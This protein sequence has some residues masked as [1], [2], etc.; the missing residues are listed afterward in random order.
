[1]IR[2]KLNARRGIFMRWNEI[3]LDNVNEEIK[4]FRN[5]IFGYNLYGLETDKIRN[6]VESISYVIVDEDVMI[7]SFGSQGAVTV[8][9][10][11]DDIS[12]RGNV[13]EPSVEFCKNLTKLLTYSSLKSIKFQ[14]TMA[15]LRCQRVAYI[16]S[17]QFPKLCMRL[18]M[19]L[20]INSFLLLY[21]MKM[22]VRISMMT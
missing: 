18:K 8:N 4:K 7:F 1:M 15:A 2:Y 5:H 21:L 11:D 13:P 12:V 3:I 14:V 9:M 17:C 22:P 19:M 16:A 10:V 6:A 20:I